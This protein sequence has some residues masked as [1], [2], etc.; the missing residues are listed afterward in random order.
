MVAPTPPLPFCLQPR[1]GLP[2]CA[3]LLFACRTENGLLQVAPPEEAEGADSGQVDTALPLDSAAPPATTP[4]YADADGDGYGDPDEVIEAANQP[5]GYVAD[6]SDCDDSDALLVFVCPELG[7]GG[8]GEIVVPDNFNPSR[9]ATG[10]RTSPDG[11][12]WRLLG[13][14]EGTELQAESTEGIGVGDL[15]LI[16]A[17]AGNGAWELG[18][19]AAVSEAG[20]SLTAALTRTYS[21]TAIVQRVPQ[22]QILSVYGILTTSAW[23]D[24]EGLPRATGIIALKVRQR[25]E[26]FGEIAGAGLGYAGGCGDGPH[27]PLGELEI[28]GGVGADGGWAD[29]GAGGGVAGA[30]SGGAGSDT[31]DHQ[32]GAAGL[33]GGGGGGKLSWCS[34]GRP[35]GGGGAGGGGAAYA[36]AGNDSTSALDT[37]LHGGGGAA[38]AAGGESGGD[39]KAGTTIGPGGGP[40]GSE[41]AS[42]GGGSVLLWARTA[43]FGSLDVDGGAGARGGDGLPTD[44]TAY[45]DGAGGGGS[46]GQGAAGGTVRLVCIECGFGSITARGGAGGDGGTGGAGFKSTGGAGG[47]GAGWGGA[48]TSGSEGAY[49][50]DGGGPGGGGAGG[51]AGQGG[52]IWAGF[53]LL[54]GAQVGSTEAEEALG[55][56]AA[57]REV[58][59]SAFGP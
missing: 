51:E 22:Y 46:G 39:A 30:V 55:S 16:S 10:T 35:Q 53:T 38:G 47:L 4:W 27:G 6:A 15:V 13:T 49:S 31:C 23:D 42:S 29:G 50:G 41:C 26:V 7:D 48:P 58:S 45:D 20:L 8:D 25:L 43:V 18:E 40:V 59:G 56:A 54:N 19:V 33:G 44:A 52:V 57:G 3:V 5:A 28:G 17:I 21:G 24:L 37:L 34:G 36:G 12:A 2:L 1:A 11:V 32:G 9:D 14:V